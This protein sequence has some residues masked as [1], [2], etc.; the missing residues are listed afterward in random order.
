M[1]RKERLRLWAHEHLDVQDLVL[2]VIFVLCYY[3]VL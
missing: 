2:I 1:H 3:L